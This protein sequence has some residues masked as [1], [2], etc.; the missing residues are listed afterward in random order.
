MA[1]IDDRNEQ[2][3]MVANATVYFKELG[4]TYN[5]EAFFTRDAVKRTL[6]EIYEVFTADAEKIV[7]NLPGPAQKRGNQIFMEFINKEDYYMD[8][9]KNSLLCT[10]TDLLQDINGLILVDCSIIDKF[11]QAFAIDPEGKV[12]SRVSNLANDVARNMLQK[13]QSLVNRPIEFPDELADV[14]LSNNGGKP[15]VTLQEI[16]NYQKKQSLYHWWLV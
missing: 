12:L 4:L 13:F 11:N 8:D 3:K 16:K 2:L 10:V 14:L 7:S 9:V 5:F 15:I 6:H 1:I